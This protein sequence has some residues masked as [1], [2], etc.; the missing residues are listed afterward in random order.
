MKSLPT[1]VEGTLRKTAL[2][3]PDCIRACSGILVLGKRIKS[4]VF[5]TDVS[6]IRNVN[7]DAIIAVYPF[8]PQPVITQSL[9]TAADI[10]VFVGVGGGLTQGQRVVNLSMFAEMQGAMGVVV[11]APTTN[12]VIEKMAATI[13]IPI[14]V[15]VAREDTD[16]QARVDAGVSI[17]NVSAAGRTPE[18]V[19]AI[20]AKFPQFPIVA[21]GGPTEES[22]TRTIEAGANAITWTPPTCAEIFKE[23]MDAYRDGKSY[24]D[25]H[26]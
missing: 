13:D 19:A 16:F 17:F 7:A 2:K 26:R 14:M 1:P 15:T 23:I 10:P 4:L 12:E 25:V 9:M 24:S 18:V 21:T 8:T 6:I 20:R 22:I 11:N 3:V 5:T